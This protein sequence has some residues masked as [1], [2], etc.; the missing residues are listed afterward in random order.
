MLFSEAL[1]TAVLLIDRTKDFARPS[2]SALAGQGNKSIT[3]RRQPVEMAAG[4]PETLPEARRSCEIKACSKGMPF[5]VTFL[6]DGKESLVCAV[7][8]S[9][10]W[11]AT[12]N[13]G[14]HVLQVRGV[15]TPVVLRPT[16]IY[17]QLRYGEVVFRSERTQASCRLELQ[18]GD[19]VT[20]FL[21]RPSEPF[22]TRFLRVRDVDMALTL[23]EIHW[24]RGLLEWERKEKATGYPNSLFY[25]VDPEWGPE[26]VFAE[27]ARTV[28]TAIHARPTQHGFYAG[29]CHTGCQIALAADG[30]IPAALLKAPRDV[31]ERELTAAFLRAYQEM[32]E[33]KCYPMFSADSVRSLKRQNL[34]SP[35]YKEEP[36]R[37]TLADGLRIAEV[38][39]RNWVNGYYRN[40][41]DTAVGD[42]DAWRT[43]E[44]FPEREAN[45]L[46]GD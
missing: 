37:L 14:P 23:T 3:N 21:Q 26:K 5:P 25:L 22:D 9:T 40:R 18:A 2:S 30:R 11:I 39:R 44:N 1:L 28:V 36:Q 6:V 35:H 41:R 20:V 10:T 29:R 27:L 33:T 4:T 32:K 45:T 42:P 12:A 43:F 7:D 17:E 15:R 24:Y 38:L 8:G 13:P 34:L 31:L 46:L 16:V 19:K